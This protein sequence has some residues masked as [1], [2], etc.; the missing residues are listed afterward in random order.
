[1][2]ADARNRWVW[3]YQI[4]P[5]GSLAHGQAFDHLEI[6]DENSISGA[7]GMTVDSDGFLYVATRL[8]LQVC[9]QP[10]R[11][12]LIL[13]KPHP[14]P[15]SNVVFGGPDLDTLYV[16]AGDRVFRRPAKRHGVFPWK[17]VKPPQPR[18]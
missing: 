10:G 1:M 7:D 8:G 18:L 11:V 4:Q 16:T 3:S 9:D 6:W 15:L 17:A 5:D 13:A 2:V 14:G 12:N